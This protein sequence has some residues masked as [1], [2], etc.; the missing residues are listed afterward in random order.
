MPLPTLVTDRTLYDVTRWRELRNKGYAAMTDT[1]KAEWDAANMKGAYNASDL[2]RVG[3]ALNYVR[4]RLAVASYIAADEFTAKVDWNATDLPT[5]GDL[6]NYLSYVSTIREAMA[7]YST[8][9]PTPA[10]TG[11]LDYI[12]ANNI[13][14][15]IIDVDAL[16]TKMLQARF[17]FGDLYCGEVT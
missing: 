13:E 2:N 5:A 1:E 3:T 12:E 8:T 9:P 17:F 4:D 10:D 16:I 15:I 14:Q 7:Q 6:T 11:A